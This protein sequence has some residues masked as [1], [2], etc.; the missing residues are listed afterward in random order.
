M[1]EYAILGSLQFYY[2]NKGKT[3]YLET[4]DL[5]SMVWPKTNKKLQQGQWMDDDIGKNWQNSNHR[6]KACLRS[7]NGG[8]TS[9]HFE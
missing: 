7:H 5:A 6:G 3:T 2:K 4:D 9:S 1:H 8:T